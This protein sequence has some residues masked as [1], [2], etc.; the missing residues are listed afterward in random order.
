MKGIRYTVQN[1]TVIAT[2]AGALVI[3]YQAWAQKDEGITGGTGRAMMPDGEKTAKFIREAAQGNSLE[4]ALAE[5]G[6]RKAQDPGLKTLAQQLQQDHL[7]A[8][9]QLKPIAEKH[10]VS[11]Q[12]SLPEKEQKNLDRFQKMS[13]AEFDREYAEHLLKDHQKDIAKYE[14]ASKQ[15]TDPE[16]RQYA[17]TLLPKLR[18]HLQHTA[19][20][21]RQVGVS[22][23]TITSITEKAEK[24]MGGAAD[25]HD[26]EHGSDSKTEK[27]AGAR[28]LKQ[29]EKGSEL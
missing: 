14:R 25:A 18:E 4:V 8:N 19:K 15:L 5:V 16:A 1:I 6:A 26:S 12:Q 2:V 23:S 7:Q 28:D 21:A 22:E 11:I 3:G 24:A 20:V 27:G 9:R 10:G 13:G 17:E 29:G